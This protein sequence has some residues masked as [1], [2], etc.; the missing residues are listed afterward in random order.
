MGTS[1]L[2]TPVLEQLM[3][4]YPMSKYPALQVKVTVLPTTLPTDIRPFVG[5]LTVG[6]VVSVASISKR[7]LSSEIYS[8]AWGAPAIIIFFGV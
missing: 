3:A 4:E 8:L 7:K 2:Q 6:Q 5:A 1:W